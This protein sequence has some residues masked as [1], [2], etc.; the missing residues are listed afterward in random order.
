[1]ASRVIYYSYYTRDG[2]SAA[3]GPNRPALAGH[4][5][6]HG[7]IISGLLED[8]FDRLLTTSGRSCTNSN[9]TAAQFLLLKKKNCECGLKN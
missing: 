4:L 5:H 9:S 8:S 3:H 6:H 2:P 1:M 7:G